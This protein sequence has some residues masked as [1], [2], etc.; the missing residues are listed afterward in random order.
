ME[1]TAYRFKNIKGGTW[2]TKKVNAYLIYNVRVTTY[3]FIRIPG[4]TLLN[5]LGAGHEVA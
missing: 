2:G 3:I 5:K 1:Q 4:N